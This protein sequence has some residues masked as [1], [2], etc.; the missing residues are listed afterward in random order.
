MLAL[1]EIVLQY[2][3]MERGRP[4]LGQHPEIRAWYVVRTVPQGGAPDHI[5]TQWLDMPLPI[6]YDIHEGPELHIGHNVADHSEASIVEGVSIKPNDA[7]K[8]LRVFGRDEGAAWWEDYFDSYGQGSSGLVF[9]HDEGQLMSPDL[10]GR[11]LPG[12]EDFDRD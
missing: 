7:L 12:I 9:R 3:M 11:L 5:R 1:C 10:L 4:E 2:L 8:A 6:R